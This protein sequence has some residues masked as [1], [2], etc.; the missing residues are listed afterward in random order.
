MTL[1]IALLV[2]EAFD[3]VERLVRHYA[4]AG[5]TVVIHVD[6]NVPYGTFQKFRKSVKDLPKVGFSDRVRVAWGT[7]SVVRATQLAAETLLDTAP[8]ADHILL[9]SG[10]CLPLRPLGELRAHLAAHPGVDFIESVPIERERWV[11]G[12]LEAER[13]T[14]RFPF[15]WRKHR[16]LFERTVD[17]QRRLGYRRALPSG[18]TAH[19]G[20]QWWCLTRTTLQAILEAP[21]RARTDAFFAQSWV[22]DESYFQTLVRR[23]GTLVESRSLTFSRFDAQGVPHLLYDDHLPQLA[24]SGAFLARKA[25]RGANGL[26][27]AFLDPHGP[28]RAG[29]GDPNALDALFDAAHGRRTL[30]RAGLLSQSRFPRSVLAGGATAEGYTVL[31]G[32]ADML[33]EAEDWLGRILG[34]RLHGHL[35]HPDGAR[36]AGGEPVTI[37]CLSASARLRD[38]RPEQFLSNLIWAGRGER[39]SFLFGPGDRQEIVPFLAHDANATVV[40]IRGAWALPLALSDA[41]MQQRFDRAAELHRVESGV[42]DRLRADDGNCAAHFV[43]LAEV[44]RRPEEC[45]IA[46]ARHIAP[47]H[48]GPLP[49]PPVRDLSPLPAFLGSLRD[50]GLELGSE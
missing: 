35:Y 29:S 24:A 39:Q 50:A 8:E 4:A 11:S 21:D 12:G 19:L 43:E 28:P 32:V 36:F 13:L 15:A 9:A 49:V 3:R 40:A 48:H 41:P 23:H 17:L 6:A 46:L 14:L 5:C 25:W 44:L 45:L 7:W 20:S 34:G 27:D 1:G 37:G 18:L 42:L 47:A 38:Y 22:P 16:R 30:G 2:H 33:E 26:Y 10:S 31:W